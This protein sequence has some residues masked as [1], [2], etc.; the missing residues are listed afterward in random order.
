MILAHSDAPDDSLWLRML[1]HAAQVWRQPKQLARHLCLRLLMRVACVVGD[2]GGRAP[3]LCPRSQLQRQGEYLLELAVHGL[4]K[5]A[6]LT[7]T[8]Q[9]SGLWR[10]GRPLEP[11]HGSAPRHLT[12]DDMRQVCL[13]SWPTCCW[14]ALDKLT[15]RHAAAGVQLQAEGWQRG[16]WQAWQRWRRLDSVKPLAAEPTAANNK[17]GLQFSLAHRCC[18]SNQCCALQSCA[19]S[20]P[21]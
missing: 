21:W 8:T 20:V 13:C 6:E 14:L 7:L 2:L 19:L 15:S 9:L 5:R 17:T 16:A 1:Q 3:V 11:R 18:P 4:G 10:A 12:A